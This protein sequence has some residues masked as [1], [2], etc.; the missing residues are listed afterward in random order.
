MRKKRRQVE[1]LL[2]RT[3]HAEIDFRILGFGIDQCG[4]EGICKII[5]IESDQV[6]LFC[7]DRNLASLLGVQGI[8][9][10]AHSACQ[11]DIYSHVT[12]FAI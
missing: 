2:T 3:Q 10:L 1:G 4:Q 8:L 6:G 7:E 12:E 9:E 5:E 11:S